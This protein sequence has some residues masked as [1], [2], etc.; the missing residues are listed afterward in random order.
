MDRK[1]LAYILILVFLCLFL[2][3]FKLGEPSL[4]ETDEYIYTKLAKEVVESGDLLTLHLDGKKW[5]IHPPLY[6][7][8]TAITGAIFGFGEFIARMWCA[9]FGVGLVIVIYFFGK[10]L[11]NG[12]AG[13]VAGL[14]LATSLQFIIQ[15]RLAIF[16]VP[17]IFFITLA[18]YFFFAAYTS[19][20]KNLYYLFYAFMG[21]GI[22]TKGPIAAILPISIILLYIALRKEFNVLKEAKIVSGLLLT[23]LVGGSWYIAQ[24]MVNGREFWDIAIMYYTFGRYF[25]IV[26][27]HTGP[28]YFYIPVLFL[29][30]LPWSPFIPATVAFLIKERERK[31]CL[32]VLTWISFV[33]IFFS[34]AG[35]K[36]P[37][38]IMSIYPFLALSLA[39]A[40]DHYMSS[41]EERFMQRW[42]AASFFIMFIVS[43]LFA[44]SAWYI[45]W[46]PLVYEYRHLVGGLV[47]ILIALSIGG[48]ASSSIYLAI[49]RVDAPIAMLSF[50]M[51]IFILFFTTSTIPAIE[52]YKPQRPLAAKIAS[53]TTLDDLIIGY[54][55][56]YKM[57][58]DYYLGRK[59][60]WY[61]DENKFLREFKN[62]NASYC[63]VGE[64]AYKKLKDKI[65]PYTTVIDKK[66]DVYL[67]SIK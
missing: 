31:E 36:L 43:I 44:V 33:F 39:G 5:F 21:L 34:L 3:V 8:L 65:A 7:W 46:N 35:T 59:I 18:V 19:S 11:F 66:A 4:F 15:S 42:M 38:Y 27:T 45:S 57:S 2:F 49:R 14:I 62:V 50:S 20:Q 23:V 52:M 54:G 56:V 12:R 51:V 63:L 61:R 17:L 47:P 10:L 60:K 24:L 16:D 58:F 22:L 26:E 53:L 28:F 41:G 6:M 29:G 1:E 64:K 32:F 55:T 67:L 25:G 13:F 48:I 9:L 40:F 30:F 37:G